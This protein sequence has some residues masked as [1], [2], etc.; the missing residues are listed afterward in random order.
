MQ[1]FIIRFVQ[2]DSY[3][4][5]LGRSG[6]CA[7]RKSEKGEKYMEVLFSAVEMPWLTLVVPFPFFFEKMIPKQLLTLRAN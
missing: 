3:N 5:V 7:N 6:H 2:C 1:K 4:N